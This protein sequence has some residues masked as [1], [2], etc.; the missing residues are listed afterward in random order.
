MGYVVP[1][2]NVF[3]YW[4]LLWKPIE[5]RSSLNT[6]PSKLNKETR[7]NWTHKKKKKLLKNLLFY[8]LK[9]KN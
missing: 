5:F 1:A 6:D 8:L 7:Y 9:S 4:F 2:L 3:W